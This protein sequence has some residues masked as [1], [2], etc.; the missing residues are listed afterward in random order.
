MSDLLDNKDRTI[1]EI[2]KQHSEYSTRKIAKKTNLPITTVHNRIKKLREI[3]AIKRFTIDLDY[4]KIGAPI[5]AY[6][7]VSAFSKSPDS[8]SIDQGKIASIISKYPEVEYAE[9]I[10]GEKDL[11]IKVRARDMQEIDKVIMQK[12][13]QIDGVDKTLTFFVLSE[14]EK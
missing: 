14:F 9:T 11:I 6:I 13:R 3:G 12:I 7:M 8:K 1:L 2:L 5:T 10:T 4:E